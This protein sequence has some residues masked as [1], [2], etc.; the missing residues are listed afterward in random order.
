M[1][2]AKQE[3]MTT[4]RT[5]RWLAAA[6]SWSRLPIDFM[7]PADLIFFPGAGLGDEGIDGASSEKKKKCSFGSMS[8]ELISLRFNKYI[9]KYVP[10]IDGL[11]LTICSNAQRTSENR[12]MLGVNTAPALKSVSSSPRLQGCSVSA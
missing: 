8:Q 11:L 6:A 2:K 12:M 7:L 5:R 3:A 9:K 4:K 1:R 10:V